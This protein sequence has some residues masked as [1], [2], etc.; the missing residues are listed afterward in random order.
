GEIE[1]YHDRMR[2]AVVRQ[3]EPAQ[4]REHHRRLAEVFEASGTAEPEVLAV[5]FHGAEDF[6]RA[7][8]YYAL[9]GDRAAAALAFDQAAHCYRLALQV[10]PPTS[11]EERGLRTLLGEA[12]ANAGRGAEAAAE[13]LQAAQRAD[14]IEALELRRKAAEQYLLTGHTEQGFAALQE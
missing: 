9:A 4:L 8:H 5:H 10:H 7:G 13:F 11:E 2:E 6:S 12:L 14:G 3:L 1:P